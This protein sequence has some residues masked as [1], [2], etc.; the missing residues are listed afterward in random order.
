[1][2]FSILTCF[3]TTHEHAYPGISIRLC[4]NSS[5]CICILTMSAYCTPAAFMRSKQAR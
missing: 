2:L 5:F 3:A 1:M 4:S